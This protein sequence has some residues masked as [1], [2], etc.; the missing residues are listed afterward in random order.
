MKQFY[1]R[2]VMCKYPSCTDS[3]PLKWGWYDD[4]ICGYG[5][6]QA[7]LSA[8]FNSTAPQRHDTE[9]GTWFRG[10]D[11]AVCIVGVPIR[12]G[13]MGSNDQLQTALNGYQLRMSAKTTVFRIKP[14]SQLHIQIFPQASSSALNT[15]GLSAWASHVA[16]ST[17]R[18]ETNR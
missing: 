9:E 3:L 18:Q 11:A 5:T 12:E 7:R 13:I 2:S 6:L 16:G 4:R 8:M 17:H 15:T 10:V 1:I 14:L